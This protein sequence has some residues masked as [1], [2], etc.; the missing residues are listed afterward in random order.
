MSGC[1]KE[2][3]LR[4]M[5]DDVKNLIDRDVHRGQGDGAFGL[6]RRQGSVLLES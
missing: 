6:R 5:L 4:L 3:Q 1:L 2:F